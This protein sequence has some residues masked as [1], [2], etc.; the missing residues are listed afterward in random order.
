MF[1]RVR[2]SDTEGSLY[3]AVKVHFNSD[4]DE[5]DENTYMTIDTVNG[6]RRRVVDK[7]QEEVYIMNDQGETIEAHRWIPLKED[8]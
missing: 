4:V 2:K 8:G 7:T 5:A 3:H 1:V 6:K